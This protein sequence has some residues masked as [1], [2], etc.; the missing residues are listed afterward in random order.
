M[1]RKEN[2]FCGTSRSLTILRNG[3]VVS[4]RAGKKVVNCSPI[5]C[6]QSMPAF[7][8]TRPAHH[9]ARAPVR[10]PFAAGEAAAQPI[11]A[12][13]PSHGAAAVLAP[14]RS[15]DLVAL[16]S[17]SLTAA[18]PREHEPITVTCDGRAAAR[19][20][21]LSQPPSHER[22]APPS[23]AGTPQDSE[24]RHHSG[25]TMPV[26]DHEEA[27]R[28]PSSLMHLRLS[29]EPLAPPQERPS[30]E[31][32]TPSLHMLRGQEGEREYG[33]S[34]SS[35]PAPDGVCGDE[36]DFD[37]S[38]GALLPL[39]A[40]RL[41]PG[42]T[43]AKAGCATSS[44]LPPHL[45]GGAGAV[46]RPS[47]LPSGTL[48]CGMDLSPML[49]APAPHGACSMSVDV[50][51]YPGVSA[52]PWHA[53]STARELP[54]P[55]RPPQSIVSAAFLDAF[56]PKP[57]SEP[58]VVLSPQQPTMTATGVLLPSSAW[59][60]ARDELSRRGYPRMDQSLGAGGGGGCSARVS[61]LEEDDEA[62]SAEAQA[63]AAEAE[64]EV[65][66]AAAEAAVE[67]AHAAR[68]RAGGRPPLRPLPAQR[69]LPPPRPA[70]VHPSPYVAPPASPLMPTAARTH[71]GAG[72]SRD[73][74][75]EYA[76]GAVAHTLVPVV[77][78]ACM[79]EV[80]I[81][82]Y[83]SNLAPA[84][85][86][87]AA[88]ADHDHDEEAVTAAA[89]TAAAAQQQQRASSIDSADAMDDVHD[90][91]PIAAA[92]AGAGGAMRLRPPMCS[93]RTQT[94]AVG[95]I[96]CA[97]QT[98]ATTKLRSRLLGTARRTLASLTREK[99]TRL[100]AKAAQRRRRASLLP[101]HAAF[102]TTDTRAGAPQSTA[103]VV[104]RGSIFLERAA[105]LGAA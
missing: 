23:H 81:H 8:W 94:I 75:R 93:T 89:A 69:S 6:S 40:L 79:Q 52:M 102:R 86:T 31:H 63:Q 61:E 46:L 5:T 67:A 2:F 44:V 13:I 24:G 34:S 18:V 90:K 56:R 58:A 7:N 91:G 14:R 22:T 4:E 47:R 35:A 59:T 92:A 101:H 17:R 38:L 66:E 57:G 84:A 42:S 74:A 39:P 20:P 88:A 85:A 68:S 33:W 27:V 80:P 51:R 21:P 12:Q 54:S 41:Q 96:D 28:R 15:F 62:T 65:A 105:T 76:C 30:Y 55:R 32:R 19:A 9:Q 16:S 103:V 73:V 95:G 87:A 49:R 48:L 1:R 26:E 64:A 78:G 43:F 70:A 104:G 10:R 98:E 77:E 71:E 50:E 25:L 3:A 37:L 99:A 36:D 53:P 72:G 29:P 100:I 97:V 83:G 82:E 60:A 11:S 45:G